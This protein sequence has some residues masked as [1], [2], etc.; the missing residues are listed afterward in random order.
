MNQW[1]G[2]RLGVQSAPPRAEV[3]GGEGP[4]V[5]ARRKR[6]RRHYGPGVASAS[7][8]SAAL[9]ELDRVRRPQTE[10][11]RPTNERATQVGTHQGAG[12]KPEV[13]KLH[14]A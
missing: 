10:R 9:G 8:G 1:V 3:G 11:R 12:G 7:R 13:S 2:K 4:A 14:R 5:A 6:R